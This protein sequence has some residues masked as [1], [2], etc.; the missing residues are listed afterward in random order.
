[1]SSHCRSIAS[2]CTLSWP[3]LVRRARPSI[4]T[5]RQAIVIARRHAGDLLVEPSLVDLQPMSRS[6]RAAAAALKGLQ[7]LVEV[8]E[9]VSENFAGAGNA[10]DVSRDRSARRDSLIEYLVGNAA[11]LAL[12][13]QRRRRIVR[14]MRVLLSRQ[15]QR[16]VIGQPIASAE[17]AAD[18]LG[19]NGPTSVSA[20]MPAFVAIDV[21]AHVARRLVGALPHLRLQARAAPRDSAV[22]AI[23]RHFYYQ[24]LPPAVSASSPT[25]VTATL[26]ADDSAPVSGLH[27]SRRRMRGPVTGETVMSDATGVR[28]IGVAMLTAALSVT[29][30][31]GA[32][33][34]TTTSPFEAGGEVDTLRL[35]ESRITGI[36]VGATAKWTFTRGLALDG[37]VSFFPVSWQSTPQHECPVSV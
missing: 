26:D 8:E 28:R 22:K 27:C 14:R 19:Q 6:G 36:G 20:S 13:A 11:R 5:R 16:Y 21:F 37:L 7:H 32:A 15:Q 31:S 30:S 34:Q 12:G 1:M 33:A 24:Q 35:S 23:V 4:A 10:G 3:F 2:C 25:V 18:Q 9:N 17:A 29:V